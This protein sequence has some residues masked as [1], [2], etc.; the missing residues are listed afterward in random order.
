MVNSNHI[1][2]SVVI[3]GFVTVAAYFGFQYK[4]SGSKDDYFII[5]QY[6]LN[7]SPLEGFNKPRIWIHT[8]YEVNTRKWK[9]FYSRNTTD[10]NQPYIHLTVKSIINHCGDD[11][12]IC[13]ID[14]NSFSKL[15][16]SWEYDLHSLPEPMKSRTR[17][18][19]LMQL[20]YFYGGMVV[21][22]SFLCL[23]NLRDLYQNGIAGEHPF[24]CENI[25]RTMN[26]AKSNKTPL[27]IPDSFI[28]GAKKNDSVIQEYIEHIKKTNSIGDV[29][30]FDT[31]IEFLGINNQWFIKKLESKQLNLI[32]GQLV[33]VKTTDGK[34]ILIEELTD[35]FFLDL[36]PTAFGIY[37]PQDELL[38][39]PKFQWFTRMS[40]EQTIN[41]NMIISKYIK[42]SLVNS[43]GE[44]SNQ[45]TISS[46]SSI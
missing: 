5:K 22:N 2:A 27:F 9:T 28:M 32:D 45:T 11:F 41:A 1:F 34:K 38:I 4:Q 35:E 33:G 14:D 36:N 39:R 25:N 18:L 44:F 7:D 16:P 13:L 21:P 30:H 19:G 31:D 3:I 42:V 10:L 8:K 12:N 37:I 20:L 40:G 43:S 23:Q 29:A 26:L 6:L 24:V 17:E 15:I 46:M